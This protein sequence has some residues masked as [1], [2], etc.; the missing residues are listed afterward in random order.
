MS[1][2]INHLYHRENQWVKINHISIQFLNIE[3]KAGME[4]GISLFVK[5][6]T[7]FFKHI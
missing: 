5:I 2:E 6:P 3:L 4:F 1:W 7:A